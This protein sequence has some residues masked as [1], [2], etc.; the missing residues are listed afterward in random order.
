MDTNLPHRTACLSLKTH[1]LLGW[2]RLIP[3]IT[4]IFKHKP[5]GT[6]S[7]SQSHP[8]LPLCANKQDCACKS[9]PE[10]GS[11]VC[12][13]LVFFLFSKDDQEGQETQDTGLRVFRSQ[14]FLMNRT[15]S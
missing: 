11:V 12:V 14:D 4:V 10:N 3:F 9:T 7:S 6:D 8:I 13:F 5:A 2:N 15:C 1:L